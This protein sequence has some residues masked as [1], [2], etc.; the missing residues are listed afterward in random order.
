MITNMIIAFVVATIVYLIA[1]KYLQN[2]CPLSKFFKFIIYTCISTVS[3]PAVNHI[4]P[5]KSTGGNDLVSSLMGGISSDESSMGSDW[6]QAQ[7]KAKAFTSGITSQPNSGTTT[8]QS[9][10]PA[11]IHGSGYNA[12][13]DDAPTKHVII[14][15]DGNVI[16]EYGA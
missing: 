8:S 14:G 15:R 6:Q 16:D 11:V 13:I 1:V 4:H 9:A 10:Q 5:V 3:V 2:F 12:D 7:Q